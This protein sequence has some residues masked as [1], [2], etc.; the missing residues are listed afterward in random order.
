MNT[1]LWGG[2][3]AL[4]QRVD[5][6]IEARAGGPLAKRASDAEFLRRVYLDLA[7]T[8]P[9]LEQAQEFLNDTTVDKR[10]AL[11][12]RL[13]GSPEFP[14]RMSSLFHV[15]LMERLGDDEAWASY[16]QDSFAAGKPW[17]Q[18]VRELANPDAE[19]EQT[20]GSAF[21]LSKRLENYG[22][23]PVDYPGLVRD[24]GRMFLGVDVQCAQ[25][26][27]HLFVD[28]YK[29]V[30]Y[31]GLYGFLGTATLRK[32]VK[33]PAVAE[34]LLTEKVDF[35]SVFVM[36]DE[37]TGPRLPGGDEISIPTFAKGEEYLVPPDRK[38]RFPGV[39]KF[40]PLHELA[41]QL[42]NH[43]YFRRNIANRLWWVMMGR[44]LVM[45]LDLHHADNPPTHPELLELLGDELASHDYDLRWFIRELAISDTY[46]RSSELPADDESPTDTSYRVAIEKPLSTEQ[47]LAA[48][49]RA[50]CD[51]KVPV[52]ADEGASEGEARGDLKALQERFAQAFANPPREPEVDFAPSV[53]AALF[54]LNDGVVLSWLEPRD[55]NLVGALSQ[56]DDS[57]QIANQLY[58]SLLT[59]LPTE[60]EV[61]EVQSYL[62]SHV[63]SRPAAIGRLAWALLASTEFSVN[64]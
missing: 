5:E 13:L 48:M 17:S 29:Q 56:L 34:N 44:G 54:F 21:F 47:L 52:A 9:S 60:E 6:L 57:V 4:H 41:E 16:L 55:T 19:D 42:P 3:A 26:H 1:D 30:D 25:C 38:T 32:D 18:M 64:H 50:T 51:G 7:G 63:S 61:A 33:F 49:L 62:D 59:R 31:Q 24:V 28:E 22:Q 37:R 10:V 40:S 15:M 45:P 2:E 23:N 14:K 46:Q 11:I 8:I 36:E 58:L 35:K 39:P 43:P 27:D 20:R 53:K 12:D